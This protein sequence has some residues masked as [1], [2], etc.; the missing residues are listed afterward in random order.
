MESVNGRAR[1]RV[2]GVLKV[3]AL[4]AALWLVLAFDYPAIPSGA[5]FDH[6]A[7]GVWIAAR[8][9]N[10][11]VSATET[12]ALVEQLGHQGIEWVYANRRHA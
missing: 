9:S 6:S 8:W 7:N 4:L 12:S 11:P 1:S 2:R 3:L 10:T 5:E